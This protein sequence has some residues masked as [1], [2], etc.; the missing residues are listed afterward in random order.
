M[1]IFTIHKRIL[2]IRPFSFEVFTIVCTDDDFW[3][4]I[5]NIVISTQSKAKLRNLKAKVVLCSIL[6]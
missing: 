3:P 4:Q 5:I 2:V 6:V 1:H